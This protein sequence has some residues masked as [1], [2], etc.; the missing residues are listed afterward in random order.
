MLSSFTIYR[1]CSYVAMC[2]LPPYNLVA[3]FYDLKEGKI[4]TPT[5]I[6]APTLTLHDPR[7]SPLHAISV[8]QNRHWLGKRVVRISRALNVSPGRSYQSCL[9]LEQT[10]P[11]KWIGAQDARKSSTAVSVGN[12][13][14]GN[15]ATRKNARFSRRSE[16]WSPTPLSLWWR[17]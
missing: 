2:N 4:F 17:S 9:A 11:P 7:V 8:L 13:R 1:V 10:K 15:R 6:R 12:R 3:D 14:H 5:A 16:N